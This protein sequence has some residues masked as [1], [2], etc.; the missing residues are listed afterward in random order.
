MA[1][2]S[3]Y[4]SPD[5]ETGELRGF[6][7]HQDHTEESLDLESGC[8]AQMKS[9]VPRYGDHPRRSPSSSRL[10]ITKIPTT[11]EIFC[12]TS[13]NFPFG[14]ICSPMGVAILP[15]EATHLFPANAPIALGCLMGI[16]GL[17]QL[18]CPLAGKW[19][20]GH[21]S[22]WGKR[23]PFIHGGN[24]IT[25]ISVM[26]MWYASAFNLGWLFAWALLSAMLALNVAFSSAGGLVPDLVPE[27][28]QGR[29]SG[30]V[31]VHLLTGS[32][33]GFLFLIATKNLD[34]HYNYM[35]YCA[36]LFSSSV[37]IHWKAKEE[38]TE[39]CKPARF[40]IRE[41]LDCFVIDTSHGYDFMWVFNG[42]TL[43]YVGVSC[44]SF[45]LFYLRDTINVE[46]ENL[47]KLHV[48]AMGLVGQFCGAL[49]AY[50]VGKLSDGPLGRKK[51]VY[52]ACGIM[53]F[54]YIGFIFAPLIS[55]PYDLVALYGFMVIYGFGNGSFLSVDYAI[56]LDCIP[57][58]SQT[59]Q[60]LGIWGVSAFLGLAIGPMLWGLTLEISKLLIS[61]PPNTY[62]DA[63]YYIMLL[64]GCFTVF[65]AGKCIHYI[66]GVR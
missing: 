32:V 43:Y 16:V 36:L 22:K 57:D 30:L 48:G 51:L 4:S 35:F 9:N 25:S 54:V 49:V 1:I 37:L 21:V 63:G 27:A 2:S 17:S 11:F 24:L 56:A 26:I 53:C 59:A 62:P 6:L 44:Q 7:E 20:D 46:D 34:Y 42:R 12:M 15:L 29:S 50:P 66:K 55:P 18:V 60:S 33:S 19:S 8:Y 38:S 31:G 58:R 28:M 10:S 3:D 65:C 40:A 52:I 14:A 13:F 39:L 5:E 23:R 47:Q 41:F 45:F 61:S 64:S